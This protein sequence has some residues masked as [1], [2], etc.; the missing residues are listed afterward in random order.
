M[1]LELLSHQNFEDMKYG[2]DPAFRF[3]V[4]RA[5]YKGKLKYLSSRYGNDYAVQPLPVEDMGV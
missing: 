1:L 2:M 3:D 5:I 4:S